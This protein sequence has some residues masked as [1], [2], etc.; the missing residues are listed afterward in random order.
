MIVFTLLAATTLSP[1][2]ADSLHGTVRAAGIGEGVPGVQVSVRG[3]ADV[4]LTDAAGRYVLHDLRGERL[5]VRFE[6]LG[7]QSL[8][9]DIMVG[10]GGAGGG[11]AG[12][13][14]DL[15]PS[16]VTLPPLAVLP[17]DPP[18]PQPLTDSTE[19]GSV[20]LTQASARR[21]PLV[22]ESDPLA[23][24]AAAP[25]ISGREELA[26][27]LRVRGGSGDENL[28]LLD[29]LPWRGPRPPG[30]TMGMLPSSAVTAVDV[31]TAVPPA[32]YGDALSSTIVLQPQIGGHRS[33]EG[34]VDPTAVEQAAGTPLGLHGATLFVSGRRTYRPV[35]S[36]ADETGEGA[37]GFG[38]VFG[39][40]SVPAPRGSFDF[41]YL[42]SNH[43]LAFPGQAERANPDSARPGPPQNEFAATG[44]LGGVVWTGALGETRTAQARVWYSEVA[45]EAIWG[46]LSVVS[47]LRDAGVS[48][49]Y[50]S[51]RTEAGFSVSQI[52]TAYRVQHGTSPTLVLDA[53]PAVAAVF[54]S[55]RW[56]PARPWTLSTGVRLSATSTWGLYV[57]PRVWTQVAL[58]RR[59]SVSLGYARLHQYV[60][61]AR[62]EESVVDALIGADFPI[63][64]GSGGLPPARS[65]QLTGAIGARFGAHTTVQVA[66]YARRLSGLALIPL[67]TP[68]PFAD[69]V[70]PVGRGSVWGGDA[71][72]T[73]PGDRLDLRVQ[74]GLLGS[75]RTAGA[76]RYRTGDARGRLAVGLGYQLPRSTAVRLALW[77]GAGRPTTLLQDGMQLE[78]A[79]LRGTGE[80]AG[81]PEAVAGTPNGAQLPRYVRVDLGFSKSLAVA[82]GGAPR[83]ST[84]LTVANL[85]NR[86]NALA[87]V[88]SPD[89]QQPVFLLS[90]TLLLRVRW[91]LSH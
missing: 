74:L 7:F 56:V 91:Y 71:T 38:D 48:A 77:A 36:Q 70:V 67:A 42:G 11:G 9:V 87:F 2:P 40:L 80:L 54:A 90:R 1:A 31:H 25:F 49:A 28:I 79:G 76:I 10:E 37:N 3:Y 22:G 59:T 23:A 34:S 39:H 46:G 57:E 43:R 18:A 45:G 75:Y 88:A 84:T 8:T 61:S 5:Q 21:D 89:G 81:T 35:W 62:N 17:F 20:R 15:A 14:V 82:R 29:G 78:S 53:A 68:R 41:Y 47:S 13:D 51:G 4:V 26:P 60:Q 12:V 55:Q 65:D 86:R 63:A 66:L 73:Y 83:I 30:G 19:I 85:F 6:R 16:A 44:S 33:A 52:A 24:L 64:A 50:T 27:S 32:R 58:G 72:L 69:A